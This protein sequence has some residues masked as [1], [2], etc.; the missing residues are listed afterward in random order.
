MP[1]L[2]A[3]RRL[4]RDLAASHLRQRGEVGRGQ[5]HIV[6][7]VQDALPGHHVAD[8]AQRRAGG[9]ALHTYVVAPAA[10]AAAPVISSAQ[11]LR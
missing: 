11:T 4:Q 9:A 1:L 3:P 2:Q 8:L 7:V 6:H 5:Q 10:A